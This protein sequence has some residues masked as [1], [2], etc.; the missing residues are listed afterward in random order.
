[1]AILELADVVLGDGD[2][3]LE[4]LETV[5]AK[6]DDVLDREIGLEQHPIAS[7]DLRFRGL[8]GGRRRAFAFEPRFLLGAQ[9][10]F[11]IADRDARL[12]QHFAVAVDVLRR[13]AIAV[14]NDAV[15]VD[16]AVELLRC[17]RRRCA[18]RGRENQEPVHVLHDSSFRWPSS[19]PIMSKPSSARRITYTGNPRYWKGLDRRCERCVALATEKRKKTTSSWR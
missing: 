19:A 10:S 2:L 6:R 3:R 18:G 9:R 14:V 5:V 1:E 7:R 17:G 13:N 15:L 12:V 16:P 11:F 4:H 8:G